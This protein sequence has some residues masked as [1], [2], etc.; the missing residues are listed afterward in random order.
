MVPDGLCPWVRG[1][2]IACSRCRGRL[3]CGR[4]LYPSSQAR[5][6]IVIIVH[7][8]RSNSNTY[9]CVD[10]NYMLL[11]NSYSMHL[12]FR[13]GCYQ[14]PFSPTCIIKPGNL[15]FQ[16]R[17]DIQHTVCTYIIRMLNR[18]NIGACN[19]IFLILPHVCDKS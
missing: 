8:L 19:L 2:C 1:G 6:I 16:V 13:K 18:A 12:K 9:F 7:I 5:R 15:H 11:C 4:D 14:I 17:R 10:G 3:R